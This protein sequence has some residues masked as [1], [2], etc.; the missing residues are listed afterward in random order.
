MKNRCRDNEYIFNAEFIT[1]DCSKVQVF[2]ILSY[3]FIFLVWVIIYFKSQLFKNAL[4][5]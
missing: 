4:K 3:F 1:A 2:K 5:H